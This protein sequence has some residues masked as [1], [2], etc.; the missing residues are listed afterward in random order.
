MIDNGQKG[1]REMVS[2]RGKDTQYDNFV[3]EKSI[4]SN[5]FEKDIRRVYIYKKA[6]RLAKAIHLIAPAFAQSPSLRNRMD[7]IAIGLI[8]AAI[9]PPFSARDLLSK[10]LLA[11]SSVLAIARTGNLLSAMNAD[12]IAKEAHGLLQEVAAYEEPHLFLEEAPT[13]A[14]LA[15]NAGQRRRSEI[16]QKPSRVSS[17]SAALAG[18]SSKGHIKDI[19]RTDRKGKIISVLKSKGQASIKDISTLIR[20]VSEKT[21]QRELQSL[22]EQGMVK[23]SGERRW[24]TYTLL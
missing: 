18:E 7:S 24:S 4:F 13:L 15:K 17:G 9:L 6:E 16:T 20:G 22:V 3:L 1:N 2:A 11:L 14:G 8:D 23:K 19:D 5:I 12:I 21:I 10:E